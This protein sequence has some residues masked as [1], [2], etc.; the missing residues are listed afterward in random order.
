MLII[1]LRVENDMDNNNSNH[2]VL[3]REPG[4]L[5]VHATSIG[6]D[7]L[8]SIGKIVGVIE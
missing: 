4:W 1:C 7:D 2:L 5:V 8:I 3:S 6:V